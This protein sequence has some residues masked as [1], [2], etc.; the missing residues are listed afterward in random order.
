MKP[1]RMYSTQT[2]PYCHRAKALLQQRGVDHIDEIRAKGVDRVVPVGQALLGW[3]HGAQRQ[4]AR[5]EC[6]ASRKRLAEIF[7]INLIEARPFGDV[8]EPYLHPHDIT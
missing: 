6:A 4:P 3:R 5:S 2:C 8:G 7:A 1:V